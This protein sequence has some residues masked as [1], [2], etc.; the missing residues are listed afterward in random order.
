MCYTTISVSKL[1]TAH[2]LLHKI[3]TNRRTP[4]SKVSKQP[5]PPFAQ[6]LAAHHY[7]PNLLPHPVWQLHL[8]SSYHYQGSDQQRHRSS[9]SV[10]SS[11]IVDPSPIANRCGGVVEPLCVVCG[12]CAIDSPQSITASIIN[13][14]EGRD[15]VSCCSYH[16]NRWSVPCSGVEGNWRYY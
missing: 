5:H 9:A 10:D 1:T 3:I 14:Q 8:R 6:V 13:L 11:L 16:Q 12:N 15:R 2:F 7:P 4:L